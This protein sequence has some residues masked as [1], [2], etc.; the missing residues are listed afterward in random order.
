MKNG[1]PLTNTAHF[2][3]QASNGP[4]TDDYAV[5]YCVDRESILG[6]SAMRGRPRVS[7]VFILKRHSLAT[8]EKCGA[9]DILF[10]SSGCCV[11]VGRFEQLKKGPM[12][13]ILLVRRLIGMCIEGVSAAGDVT[14]VPFRP[15]VAEERRVVLE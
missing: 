3:N 2:H 8:A 14:V 6:L 7:C 9:E 15:A 12:S 5:H 4:P 10:A 11:R 1:G 13:V